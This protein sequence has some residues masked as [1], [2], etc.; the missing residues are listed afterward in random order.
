MARSPP[1]LPQLPWTAHT[2][3]SA[4][5]ARVAVTCLVGQAR[6]PRSAGSTLPP[7]SPDPDGRLVLPTGSLFC[8][9]IFAGTA[10]G[11]CGRLPIVS[12]HVGWPAGA[13]GRCWSSPRT[14][15]SSP[16]RGLCHR[17]AQPAPR[18]GEALQAGQFPGR[19]GAGGRTSR[20]GMPSLLS[21]ERRSVPPRQRRTDPHPRPA[22]FFS[23]NDPS[24]FPPE[25]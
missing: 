9:L 13:P 12:P 14:S 8:C 10:L 3:S 20:T 11:T 22:L 1:R 25:T 18:P 7:S 21:R 16:V 23:T 19:R 15:S 4:S 5:A 24:P 2:D 6:G 17:P